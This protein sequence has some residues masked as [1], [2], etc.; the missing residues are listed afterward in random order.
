MA[1]HSNSQ[2]KT[3]YLHFAALRALTASID[4]AVFEVARDVRENQVSFEPI[5]GQAIYPTIFEQK[6]RA[7]LAH[8]S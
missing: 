7:A 5:D 1:A 4:N 6:V 2:P 3:V 8:D